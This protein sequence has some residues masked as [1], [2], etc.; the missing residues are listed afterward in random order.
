MDLKS[1]AAMIGLFFR[2]LRRISTELSPQPTPRDGFK[3]NRGHF[4]NGLYE[5]GLYVASNKEV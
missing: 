5:S 1:A 2:Y 3:Y 4:V